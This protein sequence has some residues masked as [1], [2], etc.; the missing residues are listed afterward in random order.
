MSFSRIHLC[1]YQLIYLLPLTLK[2]LT[3]SCKRKIVDFRDYN[4][5]L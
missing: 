3:D 2:Y 4:K 1:S 5:L